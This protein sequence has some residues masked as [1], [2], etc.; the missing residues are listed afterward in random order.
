MADMPAVAAQ[1]PVP[2]GAAGP[3]PQADGV[4]PGASHVPTPNPLGSAPYIT[5]SAPAGPQPLASPVSFGGSFPNGGGPAPVDLRVIDVPAPP[6]AEG[7]AF[8][9]ELS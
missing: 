6:S 4:T 2:A 5:S 7:A 8:P 3:I 1:S 9:V